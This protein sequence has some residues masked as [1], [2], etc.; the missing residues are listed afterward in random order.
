MESFGLEYSIKT[1]EKHVLSFAAQ[2]NRER[3]MMQEEETLRSGSGWSD[4]L[5]AL[6]PIRMC[7]DLHSAIDLL[8]QLVSSLAITTTPH[9]PPSTMSL[10]RIG[11]A[12]GLR[13]TRLAV[14][15][16]VRF[17]TNVAKDVKTSPADAPTTPNKDSS[18]IN[19][20]SPSEAMTRHQ[21][22]YE[23]TI[24]H[25]TSYDAQQLA[26]LSMAESVH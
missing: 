16:N 26:L 3:L 19:K 2:V 21:P 23:A 9:S 10:F 11:G 25:A 1:N 18:L 4:E 22:D 12:A 17:V 15:V 24:D 20:Q 13:A 7:R 8:L 5:G 14:P 6:N